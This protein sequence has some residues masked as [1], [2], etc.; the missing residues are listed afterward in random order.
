MIAGVLFLAPGAHDEDIVDRQTDDG[1]DALGLERVG[2]VDET[3]QVLGR[4]GRRKGAG[5]A[6]DGDLLAAEDVVGGNAFRPVGGH[7]RQVDG[8]NFIAYVDGHESLPV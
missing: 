8:W 6:E 4:A 5:Q 3:G 7:N 1:I 2:V